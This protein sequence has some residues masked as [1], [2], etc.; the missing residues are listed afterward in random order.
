V[1]AQ[2][3]TSTSPEWLASGHI[4]SLDGLRA[5]AISLVLLAHAH[6][7]SGFPDLGRFGMLLGFGSLGVDVFFVLSGF[8]ITTLLCREAERS[9]RVNLRAFYARRAIRILPAYVCFLL[10]VAALQTAGH[11]DIPGRDW[12]A[13]LTYTMN[14]QQKP[15]WDVGH[16][17]SLSIEEHYYL[18][19]PPLFAL[20]PRR[21]A[22]RALLAVLAVQPMIRWTV[23][24]AFPTW[25]PMTDLWTFT[26]F[27]T[28]AAGSLLALLARDPSC[29]EYLDSAARYWLVAFG[30]LMIG[31]GAGAASGKVAVGVTPSITAISLAILVWA[32]T[33]RG[34]RIL[35]HPVAV[36]V[37]IGSYSLY[38][39]Q[40]VFLNPHNTSWWTRF[41]E[42]LLLSVVAAWASYK[43]VERPFLRIKVRF[44]V[45]NEPEVEVKPASTGSG[46]SAGEVSK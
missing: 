15:A 4:P 37:G 28:I 21:Q 41:P 44:R 43:L 16:L 12:L 29:R 5:V 38:L 2:V 26:R 46:P 23:L 17:W 6:Q 11:A 19:W 20:L 42:N 35:E 7:T 1:T 10:F 18:L 40:Q 39:W 36:T 25:T 30:A 22:V 45:V 8:L 34:P 31:L 3:S 32:A 33:R 13:A 9:N 24:I 14:F 27:D